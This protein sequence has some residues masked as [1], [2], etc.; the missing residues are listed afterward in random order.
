M[1]AVR[2]NPLLRRIGGRIDSRLPWHLLYRGEGRQ[3]PCCGGSFRA[4]RPREGRQDARCPRCNSY[5]RHRV[6]WLWLRDRGRL[7]SGSLD[8]LHVAPEPVLEGRIRA[9]PGVRYTGGSLFP[10][11]DQV[12][13][14]LTDAPFPDGSFDVVLCNHVFDEIP[15]DRGALSEIHRVLRTGGR[16]ITQTPVDKSRARTYEDPSLSPARRREVFMTADDVRIYGLD[17]RD[18]LADAGFD[19]QVVDYAVELEP[20]AVERHGLVER[21]GRVNGTDIYVAVKQ[22]G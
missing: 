7:E 16:L 13:V 3:C 18:R 9:L 19:V 22:P 20:E 11:G 14:D 21:G 1:G 6:L 12:R 2:D 17:F 5:E 10:T 15:D 8:V 4:F